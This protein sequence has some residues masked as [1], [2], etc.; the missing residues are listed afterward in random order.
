MLLFII[1]GH[2]RAYDFNFYGFKCPNLCG[3]SYK[4]KRNLVNHLKI[5]CGKNPKFK[6]PY[7]NKTSFYNANLKKHIF[8]IH[9]IIS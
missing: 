3:R 7:C 8:N 2:Y 9:K 1:I 5:E 6:C 4:Y